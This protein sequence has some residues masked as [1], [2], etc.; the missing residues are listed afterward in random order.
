MKICLIDDEEDIRLLMT[1]LFE[2]LGHS[3]QCFENCESFL[4]ILE[5]EKPEFD[6]IISDKR[7]VD[8]MNGIECAEKLMELGIP[9][10]VVLMTGDGEQ[11]PAEAPLPSNIKAVLPKPFG[12]DDLKHCLNKATGQ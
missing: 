3:S 4:E 2:V 12:L 7:I 5:K 9:A 8:C 1:D 6:V 10:P 11:G